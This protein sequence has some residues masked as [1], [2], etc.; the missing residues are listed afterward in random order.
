MFFFLEQVKQVEQG[1]I[2]QVWDLHRVSLNIYSYFEKGCQIKCTRQ[3]RKVLWVVL[4]S[5]FFKEFERMAGEAV[6]ICLRVLKE[7]NKT[8]VSGTVH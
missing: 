8:P 7:S 1:V 3:P 4:S 5:L 2:F 6:D